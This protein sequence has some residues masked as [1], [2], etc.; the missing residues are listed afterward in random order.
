MINILGIAF[1]VAFVTAGAIIITVA[2]LY[3]WDIV[4]G[5]A[6]AMDVHSGQ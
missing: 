3:A 1:A 2:A 6:E 4:Q 5:F